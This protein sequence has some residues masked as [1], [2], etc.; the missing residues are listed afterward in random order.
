MLRSIKLLPPVP[1]DPDEY[2][3]LEDTCR[4]LLAGARRE[5][6][7]GTPI[8]CPDTAGVYE[9]CWTRDFCH[10]VEYA[11]GLL[12]PEEVLA[13]ID[14]LLAGQR[15]DGTI[16]DRVRLDG[17]PVYFAGPEDAPL[18]SAPP[19]DSALFMAK[20]L[21]AYYL[22]T[23][24]AAG[25]LQRLPQLLRA[26]ETVPLNVEG[27]VYV[28]ANRPHPSYGFADTVALTGKVFFASL[29]WWESC[30]RLAVRLQE[31]EDHEEARIWFDATE[32][33]LKLLPELYDDEMNLYWAASEDGRQHDLWG[34]VYASVIRIASKR[35]ARLI[36]EFLRDNADLTRQHGSLRHLLRGEYWQRLLT[37]VPPETYQNGA[38]WT[39]PSGWLVQTIA[40]VDMVA[41]QDLVS[42]ILATWREQGEVY[43]C[44][45]PYDDPRVPGYVV[46]ATNLLGAVKSG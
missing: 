13:G 18:G 30:R 39:V 3:Y 14:F 23:G 40:L 11:G 43:E 21:D 34:S 10:M 26:M 22:H 28:D 32:G 25:W 45:S 6:H 24:D 37:P 7:D 12:P 16:P 31:L 15:E 8:Y 17:T 41:A 19:A 9:G 36:A 2:Q 35:Q 27:M 44:L 1:I 4:R 42:E 5:A 29:L 20:L 33:P 38:Y 46:S